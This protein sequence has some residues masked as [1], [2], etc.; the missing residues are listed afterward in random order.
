MFLSACAN[1][2]SYRM[3]R[4]SLY[5]KWNFT[6][7]GRP[8]KGTAYTCLFLLFFYLFIYFFFFFFVFLFFQPCFIRETTFVTSTIAALLCLCIGGF[9]CSVC[10]VIICSLHYENAY[11]NIEN[12]TTKKKNKKNW[13]FSVKKS[14]IF[15]IS[16]QNVD[17]GYSLEPPRLGGS[18]EYTQ[19][20]FLSRNRKNNVYPCKPQFYYIKVGF[21][22]IKII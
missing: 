21:N 3:I 12:F 22:G 2:T 15:H 10:F 17:C 20:M 1:G 5:N 4:L 7:Q 14:D 8:F 18:N 9:I 6:Q 19:S 11:S 16:T 13:K